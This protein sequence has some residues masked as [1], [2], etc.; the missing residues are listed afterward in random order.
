MG[1][2]RDDHVLSRPLLLPAQA[3]R[4]KRRH[5]KSRNGCVTCKLRRV[6]VGTSFRVSRV[7]DVV[8]TL[9]MSCFLSL[10]AMNPCRVVGSARREAS[11]ASTLLRM[12]S[13]QPLRLLRSSRPLTVRSLSRT[14]LFILRFRML[15]CG[16]TTWFTPA[17]QSQHR[18][19]IRLTRAC[20]RSRSL[21]LLLAA[22]L[23][24]MLCWLS[25]LSACALRPP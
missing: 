16:S 11:S 23:C 8:Q 9:T 19:Q 12:L 20:G 21:L 7:E 5:T 6:K 22:L 17:R 24:R 25:V 18:A 13:M 14:R 2:T 10:S 15:C 4:Q 1:G 3:L